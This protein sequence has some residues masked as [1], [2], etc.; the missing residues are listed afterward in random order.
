M[1]GESKDLI[2][3]L[4]INQS[5][6]F[7]GVDIVRNKGNGTI[8]LLHGGPSTGKTFTAESVAEIA[9][10]PLFPI[11]CGD[12]SERAIDSIFDKGESGTA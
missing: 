12:L 1:D 10:K 5:D 2:Q 8:I 4:V 9:E 7:L 11:S 3:A 6:S